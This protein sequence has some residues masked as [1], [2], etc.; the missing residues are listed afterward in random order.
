M[1]AALSSYLLGRACH[2]LKFNLC[3]FLCVL[4]SLAGLKTS[5]IVLLVL[6]VR[7]G[8]K[9]SCNFLRM[10]QNLPLTFKFM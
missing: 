2:F 3:I 4:G 8:V 9:A 1:K 7:G 10:N 6:I 5:V